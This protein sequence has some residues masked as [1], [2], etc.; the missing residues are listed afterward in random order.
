MCCYIALECVV[1]EHICFA[2]IKK[3][4]RVGEGKRNGSADKNENIV[5]E[6]NDNM[7]TDNDDI[8]DQTIKLIII[9]KLKKI[10]KRY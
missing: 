8:N 5:T 10:M 6:N 9:K 3:K 4:A 1:I 2:T 7:L